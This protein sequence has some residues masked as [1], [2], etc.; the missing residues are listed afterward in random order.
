MV[1]WQCVGEIHMLVGD[2]GSRERDSYI[3]KKAPEDM[4]LQQA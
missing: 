4:F 2:V 3:C 1:S